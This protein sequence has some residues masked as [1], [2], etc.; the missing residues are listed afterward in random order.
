MQTNLSHGKGAAPYPCVMKE[1]LTAIGDT[2]SPPPARGTNGLWYQHAALSQVRDHPCLCSL[3]ATRYWLEDNASP[4]ELLT[5]RQSP[6]QLLIHAPKGTF[7]SSAR[8]G[9]PLYPFCCFPPRVLE[10]RPMTVC[11]WLSLAPRLRSVSSAV[12]PRYLIN[13]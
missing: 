11:S 9:P 7:L 8:M 13:F 2:Q 4:W 1:H 3:G 6:K 5:F 10:N 12:T